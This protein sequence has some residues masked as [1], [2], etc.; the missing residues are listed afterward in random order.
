MNSGNEN[1]FIKT[2]ICVLENNDN[3][4]HTLKGAPCNANYTYCVSQ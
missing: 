2:M 1:V 3:L 4:N